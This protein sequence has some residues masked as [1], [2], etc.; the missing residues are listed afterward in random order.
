MNEFIEK[1]RALLH[2]YCTITRIIGWLLLIGA[3]VVPIVQPLSG[4]SASSEHR[5]FWIYLFCL[6]IILDYLLIAIVLLGLAQ[7]VRYLYESEYRPGLILRHGGKVLYIYAAALIA[8]PF[9]TFYFEMRAYG[10]PG[11]VNLFEYLLGMNLPDVAKA[12]IF[13]GMAKVLKRMM[14]MVEE[15]KTL[16]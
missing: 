11:T 12:L 5:S 1:N 3:I 15:S 16:V 2:S 10:Y 6:Q 9:L 14:P 7:F 13:I 8:S 4:L